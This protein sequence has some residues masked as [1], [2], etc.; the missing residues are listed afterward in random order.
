MCAVPGHSAST[1]PIEHSIAA[2]RDGSFSALGQ[3]LDYYR[4]YLLHIANE[5]LAEQVGPKA[6]PS[7]LVQETFLDAARDFRHFEGGNDLELRAWLRQILRNNLRD[8]EKRWLHTQKRAGGDVS[9][10][11][12]VV[13]EQILRKVQA[14]TPSPSTLLLTEED[15]RRVR[16]ALRKLSGEYQQVIQLR[17]FEGRTFQEVGEQMD[18]SSEAAR[19][20]WA[21]AIERLGEILLETG[22]DG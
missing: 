18:R 6:S 11:A 20:L 19:K 14:N 17:T 22:E 10:D 21:R 4:A 12:D 8:A 3:L 2:A 9:L 15:R 13:R 16:T 7:D 5:E 1:T